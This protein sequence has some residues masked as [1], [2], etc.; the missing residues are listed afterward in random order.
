MTCKSCNIECSRSGKHRNG[1]QRFRCPK[2]G[3]TYTQHHDRLFGAMTIPEQKGELALQ[4]LVEGA[5]I[6]STE[7]LSG[8]HRDTITRL[9]VQ[10]GQFC[11]GLMDRRMRNLHCTHLQCDEIWT[12]VRKKQRQV[13]ETDLPEVGDAWTFVAE[14][15][16]TK[17]VPAFA[18]GKRTLETTNEFIR[19]LSNRLASR[20]QLTTDG[21]PFY[22]DTVEENFGSDIDFGQVIKVF[23]NGQHNATGRLSPWFDKGIPISNT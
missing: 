22:V 5:S 6:R 9:L 13:E 15:A 10:S 17:L 3:T 7:R 23:G 1:L 21:F 16:E 14:D 8:L 20:V 11:L 4:L 2:C 12:Y 19:D 18:I